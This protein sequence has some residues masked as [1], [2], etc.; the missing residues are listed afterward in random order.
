MICVTY[1]ED[2]LFFARDEKDIDDAINGIKK[3]GL[4]LQVEDSVAGFLG[5]HVDQYSKTSADGK[6]IKFI[7]LLQ[8]R[9]IDRIITALRLNSNANTA[10]VKTPAPSN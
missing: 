10:G 7:C 2:S 5:V 8:T 3:S 1:V 6:E 9:L 4:D